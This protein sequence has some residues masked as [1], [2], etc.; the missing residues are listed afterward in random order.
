VNTVAMAAIAANS[1]AMLRGFEM[2]WDR[3][4]S[5]VFR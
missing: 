2:W 1:I 5:M 3:M 4:S